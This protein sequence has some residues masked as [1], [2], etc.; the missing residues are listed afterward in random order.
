[1]LGYLSADIICSK[2]G[3]VFRERKTVNFEAGIDLRTNIRAYFRSPKMEAIVFIFL[4]IFFRNTRSFE[5]WGALLVL[6]IAEY[7]TTTPVERATGQ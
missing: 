5:N 4:Q 6:K 2:K 3:T 1:M 7:L